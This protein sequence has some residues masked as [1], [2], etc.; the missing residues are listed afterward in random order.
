[1]CQ[2]ANTHPKSREKQESSEHGPPCPAPPP[3][4]FYELQRCSF[5]SPSHR[6]K[7]HFWQ[8]KRQGFRTCPAFSA[9]AIRCIRNHAIPHCKRRK[10]RLAVRTGLYR[11]PV[12]S[13]ER[14]G[15]N[16]YLPPCGRTRRQLRRAQSSVLMHV[17]HA[18][19]LR[20][21]LLPEFLS[22]T[23]LSHT[24]SPIIWTFN[25]KNQFF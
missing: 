12:R 21:P 13:S 22:V 25:A 4:R 8:S 24:M 7:H 3:G 2:G 16:L 17:L 19:P 18:H 11:E 23:L 14:Q 15:S 9:T 20:T 5:R 6:Q 10:F 1:M